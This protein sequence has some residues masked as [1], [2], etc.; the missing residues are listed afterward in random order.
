MQPTMQPTTQ[1]TLN[2][3]SIK[4]PALNSV[5]LQR[6]IKEVKWKKNKCHALAVTMTEFIT[7][8]IAN[9]VQ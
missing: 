2:V 6:L 4:Q 1:S 5:V 9:N 7:D 8:I 3:N